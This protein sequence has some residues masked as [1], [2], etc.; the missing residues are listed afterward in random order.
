MGR[1]VAFFCVRTLAHGPGGMQTHLDQL[2]RLFYAQGWKCEV[3]TTPL[4][5][6]KGEHWEPE[7]PIH[8]V[9]GTRPWILSRGFAKV[10]ARVFGARHREEPFDLV[11]SESMAAIG[12]VD[13]PREARPPLVYWNH[14]FEL[15]NLLNQ[16]QDATGFADWVKLPAIKLPEAIWRSWLERRIVNTADLCV[17]AIP[18]LL[19]LWRRWHGADPEKLMVFRNAVDIAE[20]PARP[21]PNVPNVMMAAVLVKQKGIQ[22]GLKALGRLAREGIQF[23]VTLVGDGPY[24]STLENLASRLGFENHITWLGHIPYAQFQ[25]QYAAA[26]LF[27]M[28]TRR[29]E[30]GPLVISEA[31]GSRVPVVATDRGGNADS[32][33]PAGIVVP[34]GDIEALASAV[35]HIL[36]DAGL[37]AELRETARKQWEDLFSPSASRRNMDAMLGRLGLAG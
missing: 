31:L 37:H 26:D 28:P 13:L 16:C 18:R 8:F 34:V 19:G 32:V 17:G 10:S 30:G 9:E 1:R 21:L 20:V 36:G 3:F 27:L 14:G 7:C 5:P 15:E 4:L 6:D 11:L 29:F 33:G 2:I 12:L 23:H 25:L 24:R 35:R 22:D